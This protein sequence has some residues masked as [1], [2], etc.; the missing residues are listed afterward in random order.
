MIAHHL[1]KSINQINF[2]QAGLHLAGSISHFGFEDSGEQLKATK[3]CNGANS[4]F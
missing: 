1:V 4:R 2:V 3:V